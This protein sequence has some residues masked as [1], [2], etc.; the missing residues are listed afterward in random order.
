M[1]HNHGIR[2]MIGNDDSAMRYV[3]AAGRKRPRRAPN[4]GPFDG[5]VFDFNADMR[6]LATEQR[7]RI[8]QVIDE[9]GAALGGVVNR[10]RGL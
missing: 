10:V 8:Q 2:V 6:R 3:R 5:L 1:P 9:A 4:P 7:R